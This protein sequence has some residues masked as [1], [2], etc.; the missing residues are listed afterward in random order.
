MNKINSYGTGLVAG[1][2]V[3]FGLMVGAIIM[4]V[5]G[6]NPVTGYISLV[7]SALGSSLN[8]GEVLRSM[9]PLILTA[10]GF[11][12]AQ[13]AGFFNIGLAGQVWVGWIAS[14]WFVLVNQ[15]MTPWL[16]I[17][18]AVI[19]GALAGA[20]MGALPGWLRAQFGES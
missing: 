1:L 5:S 15:S 7:Q 11:L 20:L 10:A 13:S 12:V 9:T 18:L 17:P 16:S 4:L 19:I 3:F 2:A 8:I 14:T 6:F